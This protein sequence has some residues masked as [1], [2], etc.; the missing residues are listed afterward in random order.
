MIRRRNRLSTISSD[1]NEEVVNESPHQSFKKRR[2]SSNFDMLS[3][4]I[5]YQDY[6][7]KFLDGIEEEEEG[8]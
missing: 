2:K 1:M 7:N 6:V 3:D 5:K 4:P 8:K